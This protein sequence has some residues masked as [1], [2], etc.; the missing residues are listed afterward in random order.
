MNNPVLNNFRKFLMNIGAIRPDCVYLSETLWQYPDF[1]Y[2]VEDFVKHFNVQY[3]TYLGLSEDTQCMNTDWGL[4]SLS[5]F[6]ENGYTF[7][8]MDF[9]DE[10]ELLFRVNH[11]DYVVTS[12]EL[13]ETRYPQ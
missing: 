5:F 6:E 11:N 13:H 1:R 10:S 4:C 12:L 9:G 8:C 2:Q 3:L 7:F